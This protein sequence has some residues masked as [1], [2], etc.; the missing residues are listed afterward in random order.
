[1]NIHKSMRAPDGI[2]QINK[3]LFVTINPKN[4]C[5]LE[6]TEYLWLLFIDQKMSDFKVFANN[7]FSDITLWYQN[8]KME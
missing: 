6:F 8:W 4:P 2:F 7:Y 5:K 1:M 3:T